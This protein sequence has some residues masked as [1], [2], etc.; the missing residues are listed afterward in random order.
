MMASVDHE[1]S[2]VVR[3]TQEGLLDVSVGCEL[4]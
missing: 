3:Q 4:S 1:G 2:D